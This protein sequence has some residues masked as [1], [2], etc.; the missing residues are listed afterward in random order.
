MQSASFDMTSLAAGG[1]LRLQ[2]PLALRQQDLATLRVTQAPDG[3]ISDEMM[4]VQ[5]GLDDRSRDHKLKTK[6]AK[7]IGHAY[8][9]KDTGQ[10]NHTHP[11]HGSRRQ[12]GF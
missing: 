11:L 12:K 2:L 4:E 7:E 10:K 9:N 3:S 8:V 1:M 6:M 5:A